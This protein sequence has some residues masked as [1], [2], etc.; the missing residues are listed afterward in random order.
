MEKLIHYVF[1]IRKEIG[2]DADLLVDFY[3]RKD[4]DGVKL[5]ALLIKDRFKS[6]TVQK[7][8][9]CILIYLG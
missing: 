1:A 7:N 9:D 5:A 3:N 4:F 2:S 6:R 8:V